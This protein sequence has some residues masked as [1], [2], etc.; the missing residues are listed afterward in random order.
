MDAHPYQMV[1][2]ERRI[3]MLRVLELQD[4]IWQLTITMVDLPKPNLWQPRNADD[5]YIVIA[6]LVGALA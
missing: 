6:A 1:L 5:S 2:R 3:D 4:E